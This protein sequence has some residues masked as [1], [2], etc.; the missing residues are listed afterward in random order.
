ML[1]VNSVIKWNAGELVER[2]LW[3]DINCDIA[4]VIN[5]NSNKFPYPRGMEEINNGINNG[6]VKFVED[7]KMS[8]GDEDNI[9]QKYKEIR[10]NSWSMIKNLVHL[11]PKIFISKERRK[12]ILKACEIYGVDESTISKYLKRYWLRGKTKN[13][14]IPDFNLCGGKLKEKVANEVKRGRTRKN[15]EILGYGVN[16][17]EEMKKIF[18]VAINRFYYRNSKPPLKVAFEM[19]LKEYFSSDFKVENG[20]KIPLIK[21]EN[22]IPTMRQFRY[23]FN[24]ERNIKQ[25]IKNRKNLKA[26]EQNY[27][28]IIGDATIEAIGPGSIYQIDATIGDVYLVSRLNRNWTIGRPVIYIVMDVFSRMIVG[29]YI[30]LEGPSWV[31]AMEALAN[32]AMKK[33]EFCNEHGINIA[34]EQW[35]VHFLPDSILTDRGVEFTGYSTEKLINSLHITI[36]NTAPYRADWKGIIEKNFHLIQERVRPFLPGS[37]NADFTRGDRNYVLDGK[38]DIGQFTQ[39]IIKCVL[40]HN[41]SHYLSGYIRDEAMIEDNVEPIPIKLWDWGIKNRSGKLKAVNEDVLKL[42]LMPSGKATITAK[43]IKFKGMYYGSKLSLKEKWFETARNK[44]SWNVDVAFDMRNMDYIYIKD[45]DGKTFEKCFLLEHQ[46]RYK[47]KSFEEIEY[48]LE[49]EK[50]EERKNIRTETQ[51]KVQL[52]AEVEDIVNNAKNETI[53]EK[54][55]DSNNQRIKNIRR[56]RKIENYLYRDKNAF[57]LEKEDMNQ[58][59]E[60]IQFNPKIDDDVIES[61]E[62]NMLKIKQKEALRNINGQNNY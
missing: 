61:D 7:S 45:N 47:N 9:P 37:V 1:P 19:M 39:I 27:R 13:A 12:L 44:G 30:G 41:N 3:L 16:V 21:S 62:F 11:E 59:T 8:V 49:Y 52:I 26:Y 42:N 4:F 22:E 57:E 40:F 53:K 51:S 20:I 23:W 33:V 5:V 10:D 34:E 35:P 54:N 29:L 38:L 6:F 24:K 2:I 48:L 36:S 55:T 32:S 58:V 56:N 14:L 46:L 31:G 17:D 60:I 18:R 43:G 25:E 50:F 15:A 28:T